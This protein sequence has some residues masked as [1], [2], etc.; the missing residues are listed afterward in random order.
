MFVGV[1]LWNR[2]NFSLFFWGGAENY[3]QFTNKLKLEHLLCK[4]LTSLDICFGM[5]EVNKVLEGLTL[6]MVEWKASRHEIHCDF[7]IHKELLPTFFAILFNTCIPCN[8][9]LLCYRWL[10]SCLCKLSPGKGIL[11]RLNFPFPFDCF[12]DL[13]FFLPLFFLFQ[14]AKFCVHWWMAS[15]VEKMIIKILDIGKYIFS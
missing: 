12:C 7:G 4:S 3:L 5:H 10:I 6:N 15:T 13:I 9:G 11:R 8:G 2:L 14:F 1:C